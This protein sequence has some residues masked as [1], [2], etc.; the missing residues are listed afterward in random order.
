MGTGPV[1]TDIYTLLCDVRNFID[2]TCRVTPEV[3][4]LLARLF[5][6]I[7]ELEDL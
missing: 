3:D 6:A 2:Y 5:D 1:K 4:R 7:H